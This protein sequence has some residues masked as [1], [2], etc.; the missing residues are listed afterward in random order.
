MHVYMCL[1]VYLYV[2]VCV[3]PCVCVS[4]CVVVGGVYVCVT[5]CLRMDLCV[6]ACVH[7]HL[8]G[9]S[10]VLT[11]RGRGYRSMCT[12]QLPSWINGTQLSAPWQ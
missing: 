11:L 2:S 6:F 10:L 8:A 4:V 3:F 12:L 9:D 1:C 5:V 7:V